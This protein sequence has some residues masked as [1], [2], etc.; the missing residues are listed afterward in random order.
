VLPVDGQHGRVADLLHGVV[1]ERGVVGL[2]SALRAADGRGWR[3]AWAGRGAGGLR[4]IRQP[5]RPR[6]L[7]TAHSPQLGDSRAWWMAWC[8]RL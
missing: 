6:P 5:L 7:G 4:G 2:A 1:V 8:R 3:G